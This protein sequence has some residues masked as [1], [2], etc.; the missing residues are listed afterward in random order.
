MK[1]RK[2]EMKDQHAF[3]WINERHRPKAFAVLFVMTVV[4]MISLQIIGGPLENDAAPGGIVSFELAGNLPA[5]HSILASWG[6]EEKMF[7]ALSLGLDYLFLIA[8]AFT[9]GL[10]CVLI[11]QRLSEQNDVLIKAGVIL[12]WALMLAAALDAL[13]NYGLIQILLESDQPL[14]PVIARWAAI[15]KFV[16]VALGLLYIIVANGKRV[17]D[18]MRTSSSEGIYIC[19]F[20]V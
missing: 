11:L 16:I 20:R 4:L 12:S 7:A 8:Y 18:K 2:S 1:G 9:I 5:A 17:A 3:Q 15:P 14:W 13:E 19:P 6:P 10:G